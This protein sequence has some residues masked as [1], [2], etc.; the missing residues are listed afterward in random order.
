MIKKESCC[1][2]KLSTTALCIIGLS[3]WRHRKWGNTYKKR[4]FQNPVWKLFSLNSDSDWSELTEQQQQTLQWKTKKR[5]LIFFLEVIFFLSYL[6]ISKK[7]FSC[8]HHRIRNLF[9]LWF[10]SRTLSPGTERFGT[11]SNLFWFYLWPFLWFCAGR[12]LFEHNL[13]KNMGAFL[14]KP[15]TEKYNESKT[16]AGLRYGLSSMQG[17]RLEME[18]AHSAVIGL[19]DIGQYFWR[20]FCDIFLYLDRPVLRLKLHNYVIGSKIDFYR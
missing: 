1:F 15:K 10:E 20:I 4:Q 17:W 9:H 7:Y 6:N 2:P 5:T 13:N 14:E 19:P 12:K 3:W 8:I 16:G 11:A 18:D